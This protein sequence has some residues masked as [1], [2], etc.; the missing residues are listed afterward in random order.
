MFIINANITTFT[1]GTQVYACILEKDYIETEYP[2]VIE[3]MLSSI[4]TDDGVVIQ[5]K[6]TQGDV[7]HDGLGVNTFGGKSFVSRETIDRLVDERKHYLYIRIL[8]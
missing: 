8:P 2:D 5:L 7:H 6:N 1:Y 3:Y 4:D